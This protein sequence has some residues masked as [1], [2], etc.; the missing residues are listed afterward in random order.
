[1]SLG[2]RVF[3]F[4]A[5]VRRLAVVAVL[6]AVVVG[7]GAGTAGA[8]SQAVYRWGSYKT[9]GQGA[10]NDQHMPT[11]VPGLTDVTALA[12]ANS[13]NYALLANGQE[14]AWGNGSFGQL[15][16]NSRA[17]SVVTPVQVKFPSGTVVTAIGEA[18]DMAFAVDSQGQGWAW[19]WNGRGTLCLGNHKEERV[20]TKVAGLSNLVAV[21]GG[22]GTVVWLTAS[23]A[24]YTCGYT[25]TGNVAT[26]RLV[27]GLPAGDPVVAISDGNAYSTV[28]LQSGQV[29]DWGLGGA[30]QLGD[31]STQNSAV[32]VQVQLPD[33]TQAVQVYAGGDLGNDGHQL[34]LLN[35]GAVV[36]WGSNLCGQLGAG[37]PQKESVPI[38]VK[39]LN[40]QTISHVVAGGST[41]YVIDST[42]KVWAWGSNKGGQVRSP[43][44]RCVATPTAVDTGVTLL[45]ATASD[46]VDYH[47]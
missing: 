13:A 44:S 2:S 32:P 28:L 7:L 19:G 10:P 40:G 16:D 47:G 41:S 11:A 8:Q 39:V 34:A 14:W 29:W 23:G 24:V 9:V 5:S 31:G 26:P 30:G 46:A 21:T 36:A 42:G 6:S 45:S 33:G 18:Q 25:L 4:G 38:V 35:T 17:N 20:P 27:T 15:G 37:R 12:A 1:M 3:D 22:G 43:S